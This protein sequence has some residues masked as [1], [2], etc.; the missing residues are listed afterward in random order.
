ML[1]RRRFLIAGAATGAVLTLAPHVA[2]RRAVA[3]PIPPLPAGT[4]PKFEMPLVVP[5]QMPREGR[6]KTVGGKNADV[7]DIAVRQFEQAILPASMGLSTRVWS[8]GRSGHP[9]TFFYPAFTIEAK[10]DRPT[11]VRWRNQLVDQ[12]G[13]YLPHLLP[14]D[15]T[16]HWANPPGG[17]AGRDRAGVDPVAYA[18]PVPIVTHVH[19][20][21][22]SEESD[23]YPEAWFLPAADDIPAG[24]ARVGSSYE[25]NRDAFTQRYGG[26]PWAPG[27]ATFQ[28]PNDQRAA[29]LWY[30]DHTLGM[31]RANV[32]A[33]PAGFYL[34]RGGPGD[35]VIDRRTGRAAVLPG[36]PPT[37]GADP[38]GTWYEI[39]LAIQDRTFAADGS[40]WYPPDRE[41]FE[42]IEPPGRLDIPFIPDA[43]C[44]G[45]PSDVSP[46][47]NPEF[48][49]TTM[50]VNGRT[51]PNLDVEQRR[52]RFRLLNG[53][54]SRF[55][56]LQ[57]PDTR[58]VA[59]QIGSEGGFLPAPIRL[60]EAPA[61]GLVDGTAKILM[62]PAERADVIVDFTNVPVGTEIVL[63]NLGPDSPFGGFPVTPANPETT[64]QV[65]RF[66][67][68]PRVG[69]DTSTPPDRLVLP[70][71]PAID[72]S[73]PERPLSLNESFSETVRVVE[74]G[75]IRLDCGNGEPFGPI[76]ALLGTLDP[77]TGEP[78]P[79]RWMDQVSEAVARG[80]TETWAF[81]N[82]TADAHPIHIHQVQF[83]VVDRQPLRT[84]DGMSTVPATLDG[85]ARGP[86][87]GESGFKD[88]VVAYPGEVTRVQA[89]FDLTGRYVW[90]CHIVEHED[91]EMMRP[92]RV[93]ET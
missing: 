77:T 58:V 38:F 32:Y 46:I 69:R 22:V 91:N 61:D 11:R 83:Q 31:T 9:E 57:I 62:A 42:E 82:F 25:A 37:V 84:E 92:F 19:G 78:M 41:S 65:M 81:Y 13:G 35:K 87:P 59:W 53:C 10:W 66:R 39:P 50:V 6:I 17:V 1:S 79:M 48:F 7:Y 73:A 26:T 71:A 68:V 4:I 40:L 27:T 90:H 16:L 47:W 72:R 51:W 86:E 67:I 15:Q 2:V 60:D 29:T 21:H 76:M 28:Y 12:D 56:F 20:A 24:Y 30:H 93:V 44:D 43:A 45:Q 23:G 54:N 3:A 34:L 88:T 5:P 70:P 55:L 64:G 75:G 85:P 18:G 63:T 74:D 52:Y 36:P 49:G 8:Y 80:A 14:I 33:G 89:R